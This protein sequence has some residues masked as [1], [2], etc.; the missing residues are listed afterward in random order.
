MLKAV[1]WTHQFIKGMDTPPTILANAD[2]CPLSM[3]GIFDMIVGVYLLRLD[4]M[5][6]HLLGCLIIC[7]MCITVLHLMLSLPRVFALVLGMGWNG[8][9]GAGFP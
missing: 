2:K 3:G 8:M 4:G 5:F 6:L 9:G 7:H 1:L